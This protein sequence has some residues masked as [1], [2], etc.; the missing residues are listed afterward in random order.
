MFCMVVKLLRSVWIRKLKSTIA[1]DVILKVNI[2]EVSICIDEEAVELAR[3]A[4]G[5]QLTEQ[6]EKVLNSLIK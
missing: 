6:K 5:S 2:S 4:F 3:Q 1:G